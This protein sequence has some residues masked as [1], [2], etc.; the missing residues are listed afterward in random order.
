MIK[1]LSILVILAA[2]LLLQSCNEQRNREIF[3]E[4]EGE[5]GVSMIKLPPGLFLGMI[6]GETE[7]SSDDLGNVDYVKL[8]MFNEENSKKLTSKELS[9][10][11][12]EKFDK[13][14]YEL[15]I[16][17]ASGGTSISA[18]ILENEDYVS[19]LMVLVS[20]KSNVI[21]LGLSG[22]LDSE[23]LMKF[24]SEIDYDDLS[25]F[26]SGSFDFSF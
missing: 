2:G 13:Y 16:D 22:K 1:K 14:G 23:S 19:D 26:S 21:T 11:I 12:R 5:A 18:Y 8:M 9:G 20:E 24:A 7:V 4:F 6:E 25:S 15:A 17:F 3:D 10:R